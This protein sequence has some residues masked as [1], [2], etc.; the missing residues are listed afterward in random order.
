MSVQ[1]RQALLTWA[2]RAGATIIEDDYDGE[3][4]YHGRPLKALAALDSSA[5]R[6]IYSGCFAKSLAP[7]LRLAY[8]VVPESS[9]RA[10]ANIKWLADRGSPP[11]LQELVVRLME[12]GEYD[13]HIARMRRSYMQRQELL[14]CALTTHFGDRVR[15]AGRSGGNH[16][17]VWFDRLSERNLQSLITECARRGVGAYALSLY[18]ERALEC[19]ALLLGFGGLEPEALE[20]GVREIAAAFENLSLFHAQTR[21]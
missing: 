20:R 4:L 5:E 1:R 14:T 2:E 11:I 7:A 10:F 3:M 8:L 18:T 16:L 17:V 6:V 19:P 13:R 21:R 12:C 9:V 15:I